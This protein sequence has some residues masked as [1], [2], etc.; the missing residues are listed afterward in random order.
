M[1]GSGLL[2]TA[3][4]HSRINDARGCIGRVEK[5][6]SR[7]KRELADVQRQVEL[8]VKIGKFEAVADYVF[9]GLIVDWVVQSKITGSL[10][11]A[12]QAKSRISRIVKEL[13][14]Q[15]EIAQE[16]KQHLQ[17]RR[18]QLVAIK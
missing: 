16:E 11:E 2:S 8:Q 14:Q 12:K 17:N 1:L 4:K 7:F 9:D 13:G 5:Q 18:S 15:R 3:V 10:V 6:L